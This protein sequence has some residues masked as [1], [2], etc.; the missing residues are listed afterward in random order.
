MMHIALP[1]VIYLILI[2]YR[3][4]LERF[5]YVFIISLRLLLRVFFNKTDT[6]LI[7]IRNSFKFLRH[8]LSPKYLRILT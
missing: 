5:N 4:I 2:C 8:N 7:D 3:F 6:H 1:A